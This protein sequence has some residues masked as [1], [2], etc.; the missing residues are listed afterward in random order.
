MI[1]KRSD[2]KAHTAV[3]WLTCQLLSLSSNSVTRFSVLTL[4]DSCPSV[5]H[6]SVSA[7]YCWSADTT[8]PLRSS[9]TC[10][11]ALRGAFLERVSWRR[12]WA[13]SR[14]V[15]VTDALPDTTRSDTNSSFAQYIHSESSRD[16]FL[17]SSQYGIDSWRWLMYVS[18]D[19]SRDW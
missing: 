13:F 11:A 9:P 19:E 16:C 4:T 14:L 18:S 3:W 8:S 5:R 17:N 2:Y 12:F 10:T 1:N 7:M 15:L 6:S